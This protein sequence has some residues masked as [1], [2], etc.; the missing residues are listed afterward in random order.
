MN[1]LV[2]HIGCTIEKHLNDICYLESE[3]DIV[4]EKDD[5]IIEEVDNGFEF[6]PECNEKALLN[7]GGCMTCQQCGYSKC[8]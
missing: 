6:C 5:V 3:V 2:A 7:N 1:S 8:G 4:E